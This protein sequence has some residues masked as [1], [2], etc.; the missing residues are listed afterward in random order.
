SFLRK[1]ATCPVE[2]F[3]PEQAIDYNRLLSA[4][5]KR[6]PVEDHSRIADDDRHRP[7]ESALWR[8]VC[9]GSKPGPIPAGLHSSPQRKKRAG[10]RRAHF[11]F[12]A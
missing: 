3:G 4:S 8:A 1:R 6:E 7:D 12:V 9:P 11:Q 10:K 2:N 5:R